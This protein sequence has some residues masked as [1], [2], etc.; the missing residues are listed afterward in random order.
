MGQLSSMVGLLEKRLE[1]LV[2]ASAIFD[3]QTLN[4]HFH[5]VLST[6]S[7]SFSEAGDAGA[8]VFGDLSAEL[9]GMLWGT[10]TSRE[11]TPSSRR[12]ERFLEDIERVLDCSVEL[13]RFSS[14][15][16]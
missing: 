3:S 2:L 5:V 8:W 16:A 10:L 11:G 1:I 15:V 14:A 9:V 6:G 7:S 4:T 13:P 12:S